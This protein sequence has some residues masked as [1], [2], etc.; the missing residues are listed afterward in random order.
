MSRDAGGTTDR[1]RSRPPGRDDH[2]R[3]RD[4]RGVYQVKLPA[5]RDNDVAVAF[6]G[7]QIHA[8]HRCAFLLQQQG[9]V[10][11]QRRLHQLSHWKTT[12]NTRRILAG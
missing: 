11:A 12:L 10:P 3:R 6:A 9:G 2:E 7:A 5:Q 8:E 1:W 4:I